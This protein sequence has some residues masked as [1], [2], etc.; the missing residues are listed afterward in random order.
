[1]EYLAVIKALKAVKK[2]DNVEI[3]VYSDSRL[4]VDTMTKGWIEKWRRNG[5]VKSD[6]KI[7][8]NKDLLKQLYE[9][10]QELN[11]KFKWV[12]AHAGLEENERCDT[13]AREAAMGNKLLIDKEYERL[14]K[15][16]VEPKINKPEIKNDNFKIEKIKS[17][18]MIMNVKTGESITVD[19]KQV[20]EFKAIVAMI[21]K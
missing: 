8:R 6:K 20:S 1:M 16:G 18:C 10:K 15:Y 11:V 4:L 13:L 14:K 5:W 7:A 12:K 2:K 17:G 19:N 3:I 21:E 9:L